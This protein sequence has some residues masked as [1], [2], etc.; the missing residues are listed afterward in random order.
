MR[1][2]SRSELH[3]M[4]CGS[5]ISLLNVNVLKVLEYNANDKLILDKRVLKVWSVLSV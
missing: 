2:R 5:V 4:V 1:R 3:P